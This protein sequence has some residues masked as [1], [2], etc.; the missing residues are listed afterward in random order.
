MGKAV[1][2][3]DVVIK[4]KLGERQLKLDY[5]KIP[6]TKWSELKRSVDF[7]QRTLVSALDELDVEA[8]AALIW[9]ERCQRERRLS[10]MDVVSEINNA[11]GDAPEFEVTDLIIK[12]K[13]LMGRVV[14]DDGQVRI[15]AARD[16]ESGEDENPTRGS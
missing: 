4:F 15:E 12:G 13:S 16:D 8:I 3:S 11:E 9:L 7:T 2:V 5:R 14:E 6:F 10:Y 1:G